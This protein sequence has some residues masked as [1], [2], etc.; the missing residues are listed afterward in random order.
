MTSINYFINT[1][2]PYLSILQ[3]AVFVCM[4]L[5]KEKYDCYCVWIFV[6]S[7]LK[8]ESFHKL[9]IMQLV[10]P[11]VL[12]RSF[13][14][15]SQWRR[16]RLKKLHSFYYLLQINTVNS[17]LIANTWYPSWI[18]LQPLYWCHCWWSFYYSRVSSVQ[19][20]ALLC[21]PA[22]SLLWSYL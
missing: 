1:K 16:I 9:E 15:A 18:Y 17:I 6:H 19:L 14:F 10:S 11:N 22:L 20:S 8:N 5:L 4:H 2:I 3:Y 13:W 21:W 7:L 12:I